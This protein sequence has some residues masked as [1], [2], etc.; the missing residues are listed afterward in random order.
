MMFWDLVEQL[1]DLQDEHPFDIEVS[2]KNKMI[3]IKY[4]T[5]KD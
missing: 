2:W 5:D 3:N 1:E 4:R